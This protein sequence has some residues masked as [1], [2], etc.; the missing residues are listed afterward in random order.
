MAG[1]SSENGAPRGN[2][3]I[4][5]AAPV[6]VSGAS[7]AARSTEVTPSPLP[8]RS[9][10][11]LSQSGIYRNFYGLAGPLDAAPQA[12]KDRPMAKKPA[13]K[14]PVKDARPFS[15]HWGSGVIAEEV[16]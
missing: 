16:Q 3:G 10:L 8:P 11:L 14:K 12:H 7:T 6:I 9:G 2:A 15:M 5:P 4:R 13:A 1:L